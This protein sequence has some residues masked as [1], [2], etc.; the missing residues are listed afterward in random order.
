MPLV[1]TAEFK[2]KLIYQRSHLWGKIC[3]SVLGRE[4]QCMIAQFFSWMSMYASLFQTK[5]CSL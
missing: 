5:Q 1:L 4:V 2:S 3:P